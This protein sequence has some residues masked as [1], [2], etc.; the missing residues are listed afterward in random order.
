MQQLFRLVRHDA[1]DLGQVE[2]VALAVGQQELVAHAQDGGLR[3]QFPARRR[4]GDQRSGP[5]GLVARELVPTDRG[6]V[7][8]R[9]Q[10]VERG[11]GLVPTERVFHDDRAV[12]GYGC[13]Q[14]L[15]RSACG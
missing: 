6:G 8:K 3:G 4:A 7:N 2:L 15:W 12:A 9:P 11:C 5:G 14:L 1:D 10:L 13:G